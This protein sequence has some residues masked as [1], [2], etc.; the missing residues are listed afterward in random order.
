LVTYVLREVYSV[1]NALQNTVEPTP[2]Y[3]SI[4]RTHS[5]WRKWKNYLFDKAILIEQLLREKLGKGI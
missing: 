4:N 5:F 2:V 1:T 3:T